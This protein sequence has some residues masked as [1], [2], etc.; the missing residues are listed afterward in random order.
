VFTILQFYFC[1]YNIASGQTLMDDWFITCF[2]L[3]FTSIPLAIQ[4]LSNFDIIEENKIIRKLMPFLYREMSN[5]PPFSI[6]YF[7]Y[8]MIKSIIFSLVNFYFVIYVDKESS[9]SKKGVYADMWFNSLCLFTNVIFV[10]SFT[11]II[12]QLY[13]IW[14]FP[15][16]ILFTSWGLYFIFCC[17]AQKMLM[18]NSVASIYDSFDSVKFWG[19]VIIVTGIGILT[20]YFFHSWEINFSRKLCSE[21]MINK[22][23]IGNLNELCSR[24][25]IVKKCFEYMNKNEESKKEDSL[26]SNSS[27]EKNNKS[28][29]SNA[30]LNNNKENLQY[31]NKQEDIK[32]ESSISSKNI[33]QF[34]NKKDNKNFNNKSNN[35]NFR[36]SLNNNNNNQ[37]NNL[38][39]SSTIT[40]G[41]NN[42]VKKDFKNLKLF[43]ERNYNIIDSNNRNN[44]FNNYNEKTVNRYKFVNGEILSNNNSK[45]KYE[46][47]GNEEQK[48]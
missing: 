29:S 33:S 39:S 44:I 20:D 38:V 19:I 36:F 35:F 10:V 17:F 22:D 18:F 40:S 15:F 4:A 14:M 11:L 47:N 43:E 24:S 7:L 32:S 34:K 26:K 8:T 42:I 1:F 12:K 30:P 37:M 2:N 45:K 6:K 25:G 5:D 13:W 31:E 21:L 23:C 27:I 3:I 46:E 9:S 28:I 16:S 41:N 48:I